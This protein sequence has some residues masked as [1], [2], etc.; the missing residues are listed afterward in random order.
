[1]KKTLE[2]LRE[3]VKETSERKIICETNNE[4]VA[5]TDNFDWFQWGLENDSNFAKHIKNNLG[6]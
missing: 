2:K 1:M 5:D 6:V 3:E 4:T